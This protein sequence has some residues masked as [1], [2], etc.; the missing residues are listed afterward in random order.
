MT[1]TSQAQRAT[2]ILDKNLKPGAAINAA[3][4]VLGQLARNNPGLF[5]D[6]P[7]LDMDG[8]LHAAIRW[9]VVVLKANSPVQLANSVAHITENG[10]DL[11]VAVFSD[12]GRTVS[13]GFEAYSD[14]ITKAS[15][16]DLSPVAVAVYG[17]AERVRFFT[18]K[19]SYFS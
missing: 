18:K 11:D 17:D 19:F 8:F 15:L 4:I 6:T 5:A 1:N 12:W 2:I 10:H 9:N 13:N 3:A 16:T 7:V 14:H